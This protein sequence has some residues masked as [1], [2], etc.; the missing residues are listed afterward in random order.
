MLTY[1][2]SVPF[3]SS[4]NYKAAP[5]TLRRSISGTHRPA[6]YSH[7]N[8]NLSYSTSSHGMIS[9]VPTSNRITTYPLATSAPYSVDTQ[10]SPEVFSTARFGAP[11]RLLTAANIRSIKT[12]DTIYMPSATYLVPYN[13]TSFG[14]IVPPYDYTKVPTF[15]APV[16]LRAISHNHFQPYD[17]TNGG[18]NNN[19]VTFNPPS[20]RPHSYPLYDP[21]SRQYIDRNY[22][23]Q[24]NNHAATLPVDAR[25]IPS[26]TI[27]SEDIRNE[28][29]EATT[30]GR[31]KSKKTWLC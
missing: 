10:K 7:P 21:E 5:S 16:D 4:A 26:R 27:S 28:D 25:Q 17:L 23:T 30:V 8:P 24:R 13:P 29:W 11:V 18:T 14:D 6:P 31:Q 9:P 20:T 2:N 19:Y 12:T 3:A 22:Y 15:V 1:P